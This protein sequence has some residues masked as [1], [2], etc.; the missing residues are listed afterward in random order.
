MESSQKTLG[1]RIGLAAGQPPRTGYGVET[2]DGDDVRNA[3]TGEGVADVALADEAAHIRILRGEALDWLAPAAGGVGD[4]IDQERTRD[5][6]LDRF[7]KDPR[8]QAVACAGLER[9]K[10]VVAG[11][12]CVKEIDAAE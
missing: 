10:R 2:L 8:R 4:V 5:L 7:G 9:K 11:R 12:A 3:E 6:N 1:D